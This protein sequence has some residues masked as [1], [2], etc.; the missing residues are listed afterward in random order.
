MSTSTCP[1]NLSL[2][3]F[4][5]RLGAALWRGH[6]VR[7]VGTCALLGLGLA[8]LALFA[9]PATAHA[10]N[11]TVSGTLSEADGTTTIGSGATIKL[12]VGTSSITTATTTTDGSGAYSFSSVSVATGTPLIAFVDASSTL[13]AATV[14]KSVDGASNLTDFDLLQDTLT[15][16]SASTTLVMADVARYDNSD[17]ADILYTASSTANELNVGSSQSLTI[18]TGTTFSTNATTTVDGNYTNNG[19]SDGVPAVTLTGAAA[20]YGGSGTSTLGNLVI[21]GS[22]TA[23][24]PHATTS[25]LTINAGG[26]LTAPAGTL[27]VDGDF[28]QQ[29][30]FTENGGTLAVAGANATLGAH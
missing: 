22:Y 14:G 30:S 15:L 19:T 12:A 5:T 17:D 7:R 6:T 10:A 4:A 1:T 3:T 18:A 11:I 13:R 21:G 9:Q 27:R 29:G 16:N 20:T 26:S 23:S 2:A 24:T 8:G 28:T 25:D